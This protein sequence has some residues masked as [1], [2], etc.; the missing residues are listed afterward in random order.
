MS[1]VTSS[2][3]RAALQALATKINRLASSDICSFDGIYGVTHEILG[4]LEEGV[5][6]P[7]ADEEFRVIYDPEANAFRMDADDHYRW[8]T[9]EGCGKYSD[10]EDMAGDV[11]PIEGKLYYCMADKQYYQVV[12][13]LLEPIG[14]DTARK[15]ATAQREIKTLTTTVEEMAFAVGDLQKRVTALE[16]YH[17]SASK[18]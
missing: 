1:I 14:G 2:A 7:K 16:K 4:P 5:H 15:L 18:I 9:W 13:E 10:Q 12:D 17:S 3:L 11:R 8:I 6:G